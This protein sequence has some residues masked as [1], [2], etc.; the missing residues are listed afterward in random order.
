MTL[1]LSWERL[2]TAPL[3]WPSPAG[4]LV[5]MSDPECVPELQRV[6][7]AK[8]PLQPWLSPA[9]GWKRWRLLQ[10]GA[11]PDRY[12]SSAVR[13]LLLLSRSRSAARP[14]SNPKATR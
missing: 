8:V 2:R 1:V 7:L 12:F 5:A 14:G 3:R 4:A 13:K 11:G 6:D 10:P 9:A